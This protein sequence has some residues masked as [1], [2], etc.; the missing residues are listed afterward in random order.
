MSTTNNQLTEEELQKL[1]SMDFSSQ[2]GFVKAS[3][4]LDEQVGPKGSAEREEFE[5]KARAW[6]YG[7]ILRDRRK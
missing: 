3:D 2:P 4:V 6:Y 1:R 7:E 5:A